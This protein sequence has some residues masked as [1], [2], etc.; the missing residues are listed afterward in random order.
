MNKKEIVHFILRKIH[1]IKGNAGFMGF[2]DIEKLT[3]EIENLLNVVADENVFAAEIAKTLLTF[4]DVLE[5]AVE[6]IRQNGR[7]IIP[8]A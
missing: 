3:H 6:D 2:G 4:N 7:G 8:S 5:A 1:T